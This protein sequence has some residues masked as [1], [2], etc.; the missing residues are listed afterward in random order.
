MYRGLEAM[1][2]RISPEVCSVIDLGAFLQA[3]VD[4]LGRTMDVCR[5]EVLMKEGSD[6]L[7]TAFEYRSDE[8]LPPYL[9][10]TY[11]A[12]ELFADAR[13]GSLEQVTT[14]DDVSSDSLPG[15]VRALF[16][17][18][19]I[20][21]AMI[22]PIRF[23]EELLALVGLYHCRR[24]YRWSVEET[25]FLRS[26]A[27]QVA[28]AFQYT[29]LY[30]EKEREVEVSRTLLEIA[31][32]VNSRTDSLEVTS[33]IVERAAQMFG[34][35]Q[36]CLAL[37]NHS[38][39]TLQ[40]EA[41]IAREPGLELE[42]GPGSL[43]LAEY[44]I[45]RDSLR[46]RKT[47]FLTGDNH[48]PEVERLLKDVFGGAAL[49]MVPLI[50]GGE[51]FGALN[52][53]WAAEPSTITPDQVALAE[54]L[55]NQ[56]AL[57]LERDRLSAEVLRLRKEL[58]GVRAQETMVGNSEAI[59][60][61]VQMALN[62]AESITTVLLTGESGTGK[63]LI[64]D[65]IHHNSPRKDRPYI[66]INCGAIPETLME[67]EL[68]GHE[69]GAYTGADSRRIGKFEEADGGTLFLDEVGELSLTAQ[70]KLLRV[71]QNGEFTRVGGNQT[72]RT[73]VRVMAATN[74]DLEEALKARKIRE[75]L[76]YRLN[77]Y[78][79]NLP[80]L[81][82]RREDIPLLAAYF[83]EL[84]RNRSKKYIAGISETALAALRAF[85]WPGNV[86]ELENVIERAVVLATGRLITLEELPEKL[87]G[88]KGEGEERT[89]T[90]PLGSTMAEA[91][92]RLIRETLHFTGGDKTRAARILGIGRKTL[93][94][95]LEKYS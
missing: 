29:R 42:A 45:L 5:C 92:R 47:L 18:R 74:I 66:K 79:I 93:Y 7:K 30:T 80:P 81:R 44:P 15:F 17:G 68:F 85:D 88:G 40:I 14:V 78:P 12:E 75:D 39:E 76:Y 34:A 65:L 26:I 36:G 54:G 60:R 94:R 24:P 33:F 71:L 69:K 91:E 50:V 73:D 95:K 43:S 8:S 61:C 27:Q 20:L 90:L 51:V 32:D 63:E 10:Y 64:A 38:E 46:K 70:V 25:N 6:G 87:R 83:L 53:I 23:R 59:N 2:N 89:I 19:E 21:S 57:S 58:G 41:F 77:V 82:E 4:E 84:Y 48:E 1:L 35:R 67:S 62:V 11:P 86:R 55:A 56:M 72:I 16:E 28:I 9:G 37:V 31:N 22:V 49:L 3:T 13:G 52:L